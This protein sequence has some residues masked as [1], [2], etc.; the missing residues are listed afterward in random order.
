MRLILLLIFLGIEYSSVSQVSI[1]PIDSLDREIVRLK[2]GPHSFKNDTLL[3]TYL[4]W[5]ANYESQTTTSEIGIIAANDALDLSE[6]MEWKH[7][8]LASNYVLGES[9]HVKS[10]YFTAIKYFLKVLELANEKQFEQYRWKSLRSIGNSYMWMERPKEAKQYFE[11]FMKETTG[12]KITE[13]YLNDGYVEIGQLYSRFLNQP[14]KGL[15][16]FLDIKKK[17]EAAKDTFGIAYVSGYMGTAYGKLNQPK[18]AIESFEKAISYYKKI[19]SEYILADAYI[20][21]S[22][23]YLDQKDYKKAE[24][25][26]EEASKIAKKM[27]IFF[28]IRDSHKLLYKANK[29]TGNF[30]EALFHHEIYANSRDSMAEANIDDRLKVINYDTDTKLQKAEIEKKTRE[31]EKQNALI[32]G[33]IA[34]LLALSVIAFLVYRFLNIRKKIAE[35]EVLQL[36]Q[37]KQL[38]ASNSVIK[39]QEQERGRLAKD[40]HDGLGGILSGVKLTLNSMTGNQIL[41]E[42][43]SLVFHKAIGQLDNAITELRRVAHSMMPEALLKFGLKD[44]LHDF[45]EGISNSG[46]LKVNFESWGN[47]NRHEQAMEV[48]VYR[49]AQELINNAIKHANANL[50]HVQLNENEN[51]LT[52]TVEDNGQGFDIQ[53]LQKNKGAGISNI[54]SRVAYLNGKLDIKSSPSHGTS[55]EVEIKTNQ[56]QAPSQ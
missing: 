34:G 11:Q 42:Q 27:Q 29:A 18:K 7:G 13:S 31:N 55:V 26:A 3:V 40:L 38:I 56:P 16:Y 5:K 6:K 17:Y 25:Y 39:G 32:I 22:E 15:S 50:V 48:S 36:L 47:I 8:I 44:A 21:S 30:K 23:F 2:K 28:S 20:Y 41:S 43:S 46:D 19:N 4:T 1:I 49:I 12:K 35:Q 14:E 10:Q 51:L 9:Y 24:I 53:N 54:E 33:L 37:E 52:L 45:C